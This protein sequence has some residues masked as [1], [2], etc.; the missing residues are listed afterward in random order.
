V[1]ESIAPI[2]HSLLGV[3]VARRV[4]TLAILASAAGLVTFTACGASVT[5]P[6]K[7][8]ADAID[9]DTVVTPD[10]EV[11]GLP[12]AG[13]DTDATV[14]TDGGDPVETDG[15]PGDVTTD[16]PPQACKP[17]EF[18]CGCDKDADCFSGVCVES[19]I[20]KVCSKT[21]ESGALCPNGWSCSQFTGGGARD[22][23]FLCLPNDIFLCR[24]CQAD[25]DCNTPGFSK[26]G[27]CIGVGGSGSFCTRI[28]DGSATC[29]DPFTCSPTKPF[30]EGGQELD[31]CVTDTP[32][33]CRCTQKSVN[34]GAKTSC[35]RQNDFGKCFGELACFKEGPLP[36]CGAQE[37][38]AELCN[39]E[40]DDCDGKTDEE[41]TDCTRW[42]QDLDGDT[43]G[44]GGGEC[45][46]QRPDDKWIERGGDC[47]ELVSVIN[48]GVGET[49]NGIDD[50]CDGQTDEEGSNGCTPHYLDDDG[51]GYG[52]TAVT[53]CFCA[54]TKGWAPKP[55]DCNDLNPK[56]HPDVEEVCDFVDN[57][58]DGGVDEAGASDCNPFFLDQDGDGWGLSEKVKCLCGPTGAYLA[59][60]PGDCDDAPL[61]GVKTNPGIPE[62]CNALDDN[63]NGETDEGDQTAMCPQVAQGTASCVG[64]KCALVDCKAGWTDG[65]GDPLNGC[66]CP[67]SPLEVPGGV[68]NTCQNPITLG[69]IDDVDGVA[70]L[71][72]TDNIASD[73]PGI[74]DVDWYQFTAVD[75]ADPNSCDAFDLRVSFLHNPGDQF[76]F[77][78]RQ[79]GCA[80]GLE[81]CNGVSSYT[82]T[83][84]V[85][86]VVQG[87][88]IG[89]CPCVSAPPTADGFQLCADQTQSYLVRVYRKPGAVSSCAAYTL[90]VQNGSP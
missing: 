83:T 25:A 40:D 8:S 85:N 7:D 14:D 57:D 55:G 10:Q 17:G 74:E 77:D 43:Y 81:I 5:T 78:V 52:Q 61:T 68:G 87:Q 11:T 79:G 58:C 60:K 24:P 62:I 26:T 2:G 33:V 63:C 16:V 22:I 56:I 19:S 41:A 39:G 15:G 48:P 1:T 27:V 29:P 86:T 75:G 51:D 70:D 4:R 49:C 73:T 20:G 50:N 30:G 71:M 64:G 37:P 72:A 34:E 18:M 84:H 69:I 54:G 47:N 38:T 67:A 32:D 12:D 6:D 90:L 66:E 31:L 23:K 46:C 3:A 76:I 88:P 59:T 28:C 9:K 35:Y 45:L 13:A 21:C 65:D 42:Y 44:L 89:E 82:N 36:E 80:A 53:K